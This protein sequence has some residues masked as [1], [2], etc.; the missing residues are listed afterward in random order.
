MDEYPRMIYHANGTYEIHGAMLDYMIVANAGELASALSD[1]WF[2][3]PEEAMNPPTPVQ[4][5]TAIP[6]DDAP[7]SRAELETKARELGIVF[8]GRTSDKTLSIKIAAALQG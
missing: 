8:D 5:E 1:G 3:T 6:P 2:L 4:P 7:P